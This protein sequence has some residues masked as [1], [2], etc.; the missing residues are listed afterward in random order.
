MKVTV[1]P[2]VVIP[3]VLLAL[4]LGAFLVFFGWLVVQQTAL[5]AV[6]RSVSEYLAT[7]AYAHLTEEDFLTLG[8][9]PQPFEAF[10]SHTVSPALLAISF[11]IPPATRVFPETEDAPSAAP[12]KR[13]GFVRAQ[14]GD[15]SA[16]RQGPDR[17]VVYVPVNFLKRTGTPDGI[18]EATYA[19]TILSP[20]ARR[21]FLFL[22]FFIFWAFSLS[23]LVAV[24]LMR[25]FIIEPIDKLK[26]SME[27]YMKSL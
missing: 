6:A 21:E 18:I 17:V 5:D 22:S 14:A 7:A 23:L 10:V 19:A 15:A 24:L 11:W 1:T 9:D 25:L 20:E 27:D 12:L 16:F 2:I 4:A 8:K 13:E 26:E 3:M